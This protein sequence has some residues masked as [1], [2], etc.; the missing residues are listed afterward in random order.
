M[1][2]K[3]GLWW[4]RD[5]KI[6]L[7]RTRKNSGRLILPGGKIEAGE[8]PEAALRRELAEELSGVVCGEAVL[9]GE[10]EDQTGTEGSAI[11]IWLFRAQMTGDPSP[12]G[13]VKELVWF[14]PRTDDCSQLAPSIRNQI[15]PR[16][17]PPASGAADHRE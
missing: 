2:R 13:E 10:Y 3:S 4:L 14:D 16:L 15:L 8:T 9:L 17:Y 11:H 5:G 1:I 7:C 6:L 12:Q